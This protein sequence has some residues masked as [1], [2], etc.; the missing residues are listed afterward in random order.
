MAT[1]LDIDCLRT[2]VTIVDVGSFAE[3]AYRVG[4]TPS[5]VSLQIRRLEDRLRRDE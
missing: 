2:F 5:A 3:A 1:N 4:R